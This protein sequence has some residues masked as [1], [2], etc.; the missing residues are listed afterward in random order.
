MGFSSI[1][2]LT[3]AQ[4]NVTIGM[5]L[6]D[7]KR[8]YPN[9]KSSPYQETTAFSWNGTIYGLNGDWYY[10]FEKEKLNWIHFSQYLDSIT[11]NNFKKC[12]N[13]TKKIIKEYTKTS[14]KPD[15]TIAGNQKYIDP[16][17]KRHWGYNV[18]EARWKDYN[19]MKVKVEFDFM[20]G[21]GLYKFLVKIDY[22]DKDYPYYG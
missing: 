20:G 18:L 7:F 16:N 2:N 8:I 14:G 4:V 21:K 17:K 12:L 1:G 10:R 15:T 9:I 3:S 22:F 6:S 11:E 13:A 5:K 19:G